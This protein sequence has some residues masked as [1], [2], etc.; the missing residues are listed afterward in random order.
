M[1]GF[2]DL[3]SIMLAIDLCDEVS[4]RTGDDTEIAEQNEEFARS[5]LTDQALAAYCNTAR[6]ETELKAG[7]Q[8]T[9][10]I[11][12]GLGGGSSNAAVVLSA[13]NLLNGHALSESGLAEVASH[14]GSDVSFFLSGGCALVAGRGEIRKHDLPI[15]NIW[16]VLA[17]PGVE[18]P[19][20]DVFGELRTSEFTSGARTRV[21]AASLAAG[22]PRWDLLHNGLQAAAKRLCPQIRE[23]LAALRVHTPWTLLSGSGATCFG[24]FEGEASARA[25]E[26]DVAKADYWT[27]AGRPMER[28]T[29]D[30]LR[31]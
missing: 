14:V 23:T 20:P 19:T 7:V 6:I 25:A 27:W 26:K 15:P 29:I 31:I 2:H 9:I 3:G 28:W 30:D 8:K 12:A 18:L 5:G 22:Q 11:A 13:A 4:V 1:D 21:L 24:I 10:P 16:I 17:N